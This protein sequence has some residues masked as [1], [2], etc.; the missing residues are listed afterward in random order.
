MLIVLALATA[1]LGALFAF[2]FD[3]L[4]SRR[5]ALAFTA[6]QRAATLLVE[7][8]ETDLLTCLVGSGSAGAGV[9]GDASSLRILSRAVPVQL[10]ERG[11][12][13]P[14]A[15]GDLLESE[16]RFDAGRGMLEARRGVPGIDDA[17]AADWSPLGGVV[18]RV[19]F[20][21]HDGGGWRDQFDS[22]AS[23]RLPRA[24]EVAVWFD[25]W[26]G[27]MT[28]DEPPLPEDESMTELE[29]LTFDPAAGFDERAFAL[30]S[31]VELFDEP[32]PDRIRVIVIPDADAEDAGDFES[33]MELTP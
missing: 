16:V 17:A 21:Y 28:D 26:P 3:M 19:R 4:E 25:P 10:A 32:T 8:V 5:R 31:D 7:R 33:G 15:F 18:Y 13:D 29:R 6:R 12:D 9:Q 30:A 22:L 27:E 14:A 23:D 2:F 20:R 24:V 11:R 1:L